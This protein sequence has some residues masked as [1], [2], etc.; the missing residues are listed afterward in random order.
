[1]LTE[2]YIHLRDG[3]LTDLSKAVNV[4]LILVFLVAMT[5]VMALGGPG[6]PPS[7]SSVSA[8]ARVDFETATNTPRRCPTCSSTLQN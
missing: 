6:V 7:E 5:L 4:E 2:L 1:M 8:P 3:V